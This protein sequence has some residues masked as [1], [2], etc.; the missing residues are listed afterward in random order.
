MKNLWK[1][2]LIFIAI[3]ILSFVVGMNAINFQLFR[4]RFSLETQLAKAFQAKSVQME[5]FSNLPLNYI[6]V[7]RIRLNLEGNTGVVFK[8]VIIHYNVLK[9]VGGLA[10]ALTAVVI[11]QAVFSGRYNDLEVFTR[12]LNAL[13]TQDTGDVEFPSDFR[14]KI[15]YFES[16]LV[17]SGGF[18]ATLHSQNIEFRMRHRRLNGS[19]DL[20][21]SFQYTNQVNYLTGGV[22]LSLNNIDPATRTGSGILSFSN[23]NFAGLKI[24]EQDSIAFDLSNQIHFRYHQSRLSNFVSIQNQKLKFY[25]DENLPLTYPKYNESGL[26][27]YLFDPGEYRFSLNVLADL[28]NKQFKIKV[29]MKNTNHDNLSL[30]L[31]SKSKNSIRLLSDFKARKGGSWHLNLKFDHDVLIPSGKVQVENVPFIKGMPVS[32]R[33]I[34]R[35]AEHFSMV[36]VKQF[37]IRGGELGNGSLRLMLLTNGLFLSNRSTGRESIFVDGAVFETGVNIHAAFKRVKGKALVK[38]I[39]LDFLNIGKGFYKGSM[40]LKVR[41]TNVFIRGNLTGYFHGKKMVNADLMVTNTTLYLKRV[42]FPISRLVY[43]GIFAFDILHPAVTSVDIEGLAILVKRY[44]FPVKGQMKID[45]QTLRVTSDLTVDQKIAVNVVSKSGITRLGILTS[46]YSLSKF[47]LPGYLK[48]H[49]NLLLSRNQIRSLGLK[50][51]YVKDEREVSLDVRASRHG[52]L[53]PLSKFVLKHNNDTLFGDGNL[54]TSGKRLLGKVSFLRGGGI[55]FSS[56][57]SDINA[58]VNLKNVF[59]KDFFEKN[60][61][62]SLNSYFLI[63]GSLP[64]PDFSGTFSFINTRDSRPFS[65]SAKDFYKLKNHLRMNQLVFNHSDWQLQTDLAW[66]FSDDKTRM[67]AKGKGRFQKMIEG[68]F[69]FDFSG[70]KKNKTFSYNLDGVKVSGEPISKIKGGIIFKKN[71]YQFYRSANAAG[72]SGILVD[73]KHFKEWSLDFSSD[74]LNGNFD[75]NI[76]KKELIAHLSLKSDLKLVGFLPLVKRIEGSGKLDLKFAGDITDPQMN[77]MLRLY[78]ASFSLE[79]L[80]TQVKDLSTS[81]PIHDGNLVFR[82]FILPTTTGNF[83][84]DGY[85]DISEIQVSY[86][87]LS[88]SSIRIGKDRLLMEL[89]SPMFKLSGVVLPERLSLVGSPMAMKFNGK[90]GFEKGV[91]VFTFNRGPSKQMPDILK[92]MV[93]NTTF[94]TGNGVKFENE[95]IDTFINN[96][97]KIQI[98]GSFGNHS[99]AVKGVLNVNKGSVSYLGSSLSVNDGS[100]SFSGD[101]TDPLPYLVVNTF[102]Q[103]KDKDGENL[104]IYLTFEGK[105]NK[106]TLKNFYSV[107]DLSKNEILTYLGFESGSVQANATNQ[108]YKG[109]PQKMLTSTLDAGFDYVLLFPISMAIRKNLGLDL[110]TIKSGFASYLASTVASGDQF[111]NKLNVVDISVGKYLSPYVFLEFQGSL[112]HDP[113]TYNMNPAFSVGLDLDLRYFDFGYKFSPVIED[114]NVVDVEHRLELNLRKKF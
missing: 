37:K 20:K 113:L 62:V 43:S 10:N 57:F 17:V 12:H 70:N 24:L 107:P 63:R 32:A 58:M 51:S 35:S 31:F 95:F 94:V 84:L 53:L 50:L 40:N 73:Q 79:Q 11:R 74:R 103:T 2:L 98:L 90:A 52:R 6:A 33:A 56:S 106:I 4:N 19:L 66:D 55:N 29:E 114:G 68:N 96:G 93:W 104:E 49:F 109:S 59:I 8:D 112:S 65:L 54:W 86:V 44:R 36:H 22:K 9:A 38:N 69:S 45:N 81:L 100:A 83:R 76:R 48:T 61:N 13:S 23:V 39:G 26:F 15:L 72:L 108:H 47:S 105:A 7:R 77:G 85:L 71:R 46:R 21:F 60:L 102:T 91:V 1:I 97:Q 92:G 111:T 101:P 75:G 25:L 16:K 27:E 78:N 28:K 99:F 89:Q 80:K 64:V 41:S 82:H 5:G 34:L 14:F 87:D 30:S 88:L 3:L 67:R 110:F 18:Y 42:D